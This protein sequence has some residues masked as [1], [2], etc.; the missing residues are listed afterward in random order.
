MSVAILIHPPKPAASRRVSIA[1]EE[2][3]TA[4]WVDVANR[5]GMTWRPL[6]QAA[7]PVEHG[8]LAEVISG[9]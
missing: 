4:E 8:E 3:H 2:V 6:F 9:V 5:L 7:V 1:T